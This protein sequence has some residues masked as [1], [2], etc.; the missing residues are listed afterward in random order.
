M[1]KKPRTT[2]AAESV[3]AWLAKKAKGAT[4]EETSKPADQKKQQSKEKAPPVRTAETTKKTDAPQKNQTQQTTKKAKPSSAETTPP[5]DNQKKQTTEAKAKA[6]EAES[7][8]PASVVEKTKNS[9]K[10]KA[11]DARARPNAGGG[12]DNDGIDDTIDSE[13]I[14]AFFYAPAQWVAPN[15]Q[16]AAGDKNVPIY[17]TS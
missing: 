15:L 16:W 14:C 10:A 12:D 9:K 13:V 6:K 17:R 5:A 8:D 1:G 3:T 11:D 4:V 7:S 2:T